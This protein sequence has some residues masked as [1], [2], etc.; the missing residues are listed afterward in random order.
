MTIA[1]G[2][3]RQ[4]LAD[5]YTGAWS[6][7]SQHTATPGST[8]A[9]EASGGGYARKQTTWGSGSNGVTT[10]SQVTFDLAAGTYTHTGG[11]DRE[12]CGHVPRRRRTNLHH[13][14]RRRPDSRPAHYHNQLTRMVG[15]TINH[16]SRPG[17]TVN[18]RTRAQWPTTVVRPGGTLH[19]ATTPT[20]TVNRPPQPPLPVTTTALFAHFAGAGQLTTAIF[21]RHNTT[22]VLGGEGSLAVVTIPR[23]PL[24]AGF[25]GAATLSLLIETS[26]RRPRPRHSPHRGRHPRRRGVAPHER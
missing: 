23:I 10:G 22:P 3:T 5:A 20:G 15:G 4:I 1:V 7:L 17:G 21:P 2:A 24:A 26:R 14:E 12:L 25:G 9:S 13:T 8:G 19:L 18:T 16:H 11:V 6:W